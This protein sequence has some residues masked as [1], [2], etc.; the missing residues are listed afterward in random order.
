MDS[1]RGDVEHVVDPQHPLEVQTQTHRV[2][3][4]HESLEAGVEVGGCVGEDTQIMGIITMQY[5]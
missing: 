3:V 1:P 2:V 5:C 4:R